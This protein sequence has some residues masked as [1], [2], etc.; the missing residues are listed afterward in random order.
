MKKFILACGVGAV[1]LSAT[2][3][4]KSNAATARRCRSQ[5]LYFHAFR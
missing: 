2:A 5:R 1:L 4:G 3:C